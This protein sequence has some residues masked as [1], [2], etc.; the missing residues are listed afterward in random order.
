MNRARVAAAIWVA[1]VILQWLW[2]AWLDRPH[3]LP[4]MLVIGFWV[5]PLLVLMPWVLRR[6][7]RSLVV[8][9]CLL[10]FYFCFAVAEAWA[11]PA[12]RA[13]A[14]IQVALIVAYFLCLPVRRRPQAGPA[15]PP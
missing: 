10:L 13:P 8:G 9:G 11:N 7:P 4:L 6:G 5:T 12:A 1:L 2:F 14:L 15:A 3:A